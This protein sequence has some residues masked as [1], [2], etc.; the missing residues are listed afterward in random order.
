MFSLR[1][2]GD[3]AGDMAPLRRLARENQSLDGLDVVVRIDVCMK[4]SRF[5]S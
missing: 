5:V 1:R 2:Y 3:G 4:S